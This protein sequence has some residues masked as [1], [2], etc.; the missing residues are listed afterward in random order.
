MKPKIEKKRGYHHGDLRAQLVAA[1]RQLVEDKG[2]DS[3]SVSEAARVAGVSSAAPY[4]HFRDRIQMIAAVAA[5]GMARHYSEMLAALDGVP[6]GTRARIVALGRVYVG[7][8]QREPGV[9]RLMF[10][11]RHDAEMVAL[12]DEEEIRPFETVQEEVAAAIGRDGIDAEVT[13]RAFLLWT[14]VHGLAFLLIDD[15]AAHKGLQV[16]VDATLRDVA[17]RVLP[18]AQ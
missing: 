12:V 15:V 18:E 4:R 1:T 8:A 10:G 17:R 9:F 7:F 16:D 11:A 6:P 5:D 13:H 14:F 3:F 2:P